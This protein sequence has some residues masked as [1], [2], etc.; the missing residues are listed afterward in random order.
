MPVEHNITTVGTIGEADV[1]IAWL[2]EHGVTA[3]VK[4]RHWLALNYGRVWSKAYGVEVVALSEDEAERGR[5]LLAEHA[6]ARA[7]AAETAPNGKIRATCEECGTT[8][9]FLAKDAGRVVDCPACG[10]FMDVE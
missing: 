5:T 9:I 2:A 7:Q 10:Q 6:A 3:D 8:H 1:I 4:D